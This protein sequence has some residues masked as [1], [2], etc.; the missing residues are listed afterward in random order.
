MDWNMKNILF[1]SFCLMMAIAPG[2][3]RSQSFTQLDTVRAS[4]SG[5]ASIP[6]N[7]TDINSS[8]LDIRYRVTATNF[9][10]DWLTQT[11]FGI[12][13]VNLCRTNT[14]DTFLWNPTTKTGQSLTA[15][16][17][18]GIASTFSLSLN[19][20]AATTTG[21]FYVTCQVS[22]AGV[23]GYSKP[24]TFVI[25]KSPAGVPSIGNTEDK[26]MLYPNPAN[27][28]LNVIYDA[29]ADI[30]NIAVYNIIGKVM[31]AYK[32]T[33]ESANLNIENIPSGIYFVRLYNANGNV[34][35]TRKF[36]KQ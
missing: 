32:V 34:V 4:V 9:P 23:G 20:S 14:S 7:I 10:T 8:P 5:T 36:T 19:L 25:C 33:G 15:T 17:P 26:V 28:E 22:E 30:K 6:D 18:A 21:C 24:T 35:V 11:A 1:I 31:N 29:N 13:D 16:Y 12:C 3:V 27:N 2:L